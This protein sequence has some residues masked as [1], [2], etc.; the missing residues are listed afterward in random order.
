M[1]LKRI[2]ALRLALILVFIFV[3]ALFLAVAGASANA[4][5]AVIFSILFI[6]VVGYAMALMYR[7]LKRDD[8]G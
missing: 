5:M 3:L 1:K 4:L 2:L 8:K 6:S 7:V